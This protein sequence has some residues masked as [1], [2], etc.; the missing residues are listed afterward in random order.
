M[1]IKSGNKNRFITIKPKFLLSFDVFIDRV[2]QI[3]SGLSHGSDA[4]DIE[5]DDVDFNNF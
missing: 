4:V 3:T 5:E 1:L 2:T